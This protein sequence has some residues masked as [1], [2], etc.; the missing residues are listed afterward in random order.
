MHLAVLQP[1]GVSSCH[2]KLARNFICLARPSF[3]RSVAIRYVRADNARD[4]DGDGGGLAFS[5]FP[6]QQINLRATESLLQPGCGGAEVFPSRLLRASGGQPEVIHGASAHPERHTRMHAAALAAPS[7]HTHTHSR[8]TPGAGM[9][10]ESQ[11]LR[12]RVLCLTLGVPGVVSHL[13]NG[14]FCR[15]LPTEFPR[16]LRLKGFKGM[17]VSG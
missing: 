17:P 15:H 6:P 8:R 1:L 11:S 12:Y 16:K 3:G 7:T 2:Q 14:G 13:W 10:P 4:G 5:D 9:Q